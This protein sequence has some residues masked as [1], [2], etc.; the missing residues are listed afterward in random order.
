LTAI[1]IT[2]LT[3]NA[4]FTYHLSTI[5]FHI[6]IA[7]GTSLLSSVNRFGG[8]LYV[9]SSPL[10]PFD[11]SLLVYPFKIYIMFPTSPVFAVDLLR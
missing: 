4:T 10:F 9:P 2:P 1:S 3:P 6:A 8:S 7:S 11:L 5:L